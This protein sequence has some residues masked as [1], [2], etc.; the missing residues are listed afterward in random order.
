MK[1]EAGPLKFCQTASISRP[2]R[3]R[4][5]GPLFGFVLNEE[6]TE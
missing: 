1:R 4:L 6:T 2:K 5:G 3:T